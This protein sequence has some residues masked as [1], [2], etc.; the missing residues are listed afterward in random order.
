MHSTLDVECLHQIASAWNGL[1][2][3]QSRYQ[4]KHWC[5]SV[6]LPAVV[7]HMLIDHAYAMCQQQTSPFKAALPF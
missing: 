6:M 3:T 5:S 7:F 1:Y 2:T 4:L